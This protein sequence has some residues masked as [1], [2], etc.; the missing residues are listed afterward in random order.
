MQFDGSLTK[1]TQK[2]LESAWTGFTATL[3]YTKVLLRTLDAG[4]ALLAGTLSRQTNKWLP[5]TLNTLSGSLNRSISILKSASIVPLTG[6]LRRQ[7]NK[8]LSAYADT[9]DGILGALKGVKSLVINAST[10]LMSGALIKQTNKVFR[11]NTSLFSG[12][13]TRFIRKSFA[14]TLSGWRVIFRVFGPGMEAPTVCTKHLH[15][16][17]NLTLYLHSPITK[18]A[19]LDG[20]LCW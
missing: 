10:A 18:E 2:V 3:T 6:T 8:V 14:A 1:R 16:P 5:A 20:N 7:T 9:L 15:S 19:I 12:S 17:I 11:T 4:M 13:I